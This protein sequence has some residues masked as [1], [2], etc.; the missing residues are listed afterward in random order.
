MPI[1]LPHTEIPSR[2]CDTLARDMLG[3]KRSS[4]FS[5]PTRAAI[6]EESYQA[7]CRK[8]AELVGKKF[9]IQAWN[10]VP[11]IREVDQCIGRFPVQ[12]SHPELCI[13]GVLGEPILESKKSK[14]GVA[15]RIEMLERFINQDI[16]SVAQEF[17]LNGD[18]VDSAR[19]DRACESRRSLAAVVQLDDVIDSLILALTSLLL[20]V[21]PDGRLFLP[22]EPEFDER[23][24]PMQMT[25]WE[26]VEPES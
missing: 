22:S 26:E 24:R 2:T 15:A 10:L 21:R 19:A 16:K 14:E 20:Q 6:N 13:A 1:G 23:G 25:Y 11:K 9:S 18:F 7:A 3:V 4:I 17:R 12:E 8:N 5:P